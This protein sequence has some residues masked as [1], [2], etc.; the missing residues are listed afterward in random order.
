MYQES[1]EGKITYLLRSSKTIALCYSPTSS[2]HALGFVS[3]VSL[4]L[5]NSFNKT[6]AAIFLVVFLVYLYYANA[7]FRI[8][9]V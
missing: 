6:V 5:I 8:Y 2:A 9:N 4:P 7:T 1:V 3:G